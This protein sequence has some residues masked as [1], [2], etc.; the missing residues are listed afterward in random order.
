MGKTIHV[1]IKIIHDSHHLEGIMNY[2]VSLV[3]KIIYILMILAPIDNF[4]A[5]KKR[6]SF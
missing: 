6:I 4:I 2:S 3:E 5:L 1:I